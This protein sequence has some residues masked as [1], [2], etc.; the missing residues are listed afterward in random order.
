VSRF[1]RFLRE[2]S[3]ALVFAVLVLVGWELAIDA[4]DV[5]R[6]LLPK[7]SEI[8]TALRD[9]R[10]ELW[11]AGWYTF[12]EALWG[13]VLGS[14]TAVLAALALTRFR[15]FGGALMPYFIAANAIPIIAFAPIANAWFGIEKGSKIAIAAVL[16]FF[17]VLVN[18][19]RGLTSVRPAQ[20][21]LMRSYAAGDV[22][23][24]RRVRIPTSLPFL[25]SALKVASVLAMIGAI[26]GEYFGGSQEQLGIVIKNAAALFQFETAWAAI[27]VAC[28]LGIGFYLA[29][30][31]AELLVMR[32]YPSQGRA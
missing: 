30:S 26:V 6:F 25:F 17:P 29:V 31:L 1:W 14:G 28:V 4:F 7:P 18:T 27:V 19:L 5:Q 24:F 22:E 9:Q 3:P 32:A 8:W 2:W 15:R 21:E 10:G 13:F 20:I 11:S 16:C 12:T 23:I